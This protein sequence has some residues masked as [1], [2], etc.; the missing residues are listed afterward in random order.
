[1][2][3]PTGLPLPAPAPRESSL[4]GMESEDSNV[5]CMTNL[6]PPSLPIFVPFPSRLDEALQLKPQNDRRVLSRFRSD[7]DL[8]GWWEVRACVWYVVRV[9]PRRLCFGASC[10]YLTLRQVFAE[11]E[12]NRLQICYPLKYQ[13]PRSRVCLGRRT[14]LEPRR[15]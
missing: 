3:Q 8:V 5:A 6:P 15:S 1:M 11:S 13:S 7:D 14:D 9:H 2:G 10:S 12:Y 4:R